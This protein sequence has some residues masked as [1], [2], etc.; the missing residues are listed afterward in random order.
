MNKER[1][2]TLSIVILVAAA[3]RLLP[4]PY[5]FTPVAAIALFSGAQF[6]R[7]SLAF[8]VPFAALLL[9]DAVLG[10][11]VLSEMMVTYAGFAAV[12]CIGFIIRGRQQFSPIAVGTLAGAVTFFL[13]TNCALWI[14]PNL[15]PQNLNGLMQGY[16]AGIPFFWNTL[17]SDIFY[18]ALLFG[19]F[20]LAESKY[21][22]LKV[23]RVA[24]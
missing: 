15:Y 16:A 9:S 17:L 7:K 5:N 4:H 21:T 13:I 10:F 6:E 24:S 2:V 23:S 8:V 11:Y 19:G 20:A 18:S 12:V 14:N 3:S 1:L 22:W